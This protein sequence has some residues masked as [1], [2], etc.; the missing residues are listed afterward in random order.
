MKS[1]AEIRH[2]IS[3]HKREF[4]LGNFQRKFLQ[5]IRRWTALALPVPE[6]AR[7]NYG[8]TDDTTNDTNKH[9]AK[10][11]DKENVL[12]PIPDAA[13]S[14]GRATSGG[15]NQPK[16]MHKNDRRQSPTAEPVA[17]ENADNDDLVS[18]SQEESDN[19]AI[20]M[21]ILKR[22]REAFM[23]NVKDPLA[24]C[25]KAAE[26]ARPNK[27]DVPKRESHSSDEDEK[28]IKSPSMRS[29]KKK[30]YQL[31]F[32]S[33]DDEDSNGSE[34]EGLSEIP[35]KYKSPQREEIPRPIY[36]S[37][38]RVGRRKFTQQEDNAII[39][40]VRKFG[41]GRWSDIKS[42]YANDLK[43]RSAVQIKDRWRTLNK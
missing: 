38:K 16:Q 7:L 11:D 4:D 28:M 37:Q 36:V 27:Q 22:K 17:F 13:T 43:N 8:S 33:S 21:K 32:D 41:A 6:L 2:I 30:K 25:V 26:S 10:N 20:P 12:A 9:N 34:D 15:Q 29:K 40:G 42:Y 35:T 39:S 24:S 31:K 3:G 14:W 19:S 23:E 5:L 18:S 1:F